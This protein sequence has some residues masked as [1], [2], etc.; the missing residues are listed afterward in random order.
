MWIEVSLEVPAE[1][2]DAVANH[3]IEN[4]APGVIEEVGTTSARVR[5]RA[6]FSE[7]AAAEVTAG[8][9]RFLD[10]LDADFSG[11]GAADVET[12][13]VYEDDWAE[14]WK[15]HFPAVDVGARLR[16]RPPWI[17]AGSDGRLEVVIEPA[18][19]FG[20]GQHAS[21][22]G[23]LLATE[24][25]FA[26]GALSPVLDVGT[27]SGIL[28]IAAVRLGAT[29]VLAIDVDDVAVRTATENFRRNG[30]AD[31]ARALAG[32][33]SLVRGSFALVLANLLAGILID[34]FPEI[35]ERTI[36]A[37]WVVGSGLLDADAEAVADAGR[38]AGLHF[39][40]A[41]SI[42][43]WTTLVLRKEG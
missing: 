34:I 8:L 13:R 7:T 29:E 15:Q 42:D 10:R 23:C 30:V 3:L 20:T 24:D 4:G 38:A 14:G 6:H 33:T 31:R 43:G 27:G 32:T 17:P 16:I 11:A 9:R 1:A 2:L 39:Q 12:L 25:L 26:V 19:A 18:R 22:R 40:K 41:Y 36:Q 5:V 28:S 21:T 35:A 37:G